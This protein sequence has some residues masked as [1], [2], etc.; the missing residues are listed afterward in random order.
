MDVVDDIKQR[1]IGKVLE[2][3]CMKNYTTYKI[4]G[5]VRLMVYPKNEEKLIELIKVAREY[6]VKYKVVGGGSN[7]I[8]SDAIY[9][10]III[11][12]DNF[13]NL[14]IDDTVVTVGAGYSLMKL[15]ISVSRKGLSGLE[16]ATGIPGTVGGAIYM[17]AGAYKSDMGY[18]VSK[19]KVLT[20][21]L[22]MKYLYNSDMDFHYRT[23]FIQKNTE[24]ICLEA[25][26]VLKHG[27]KNE[28]MAI[29]EDRK[30][31]RLISQP[32]EFPSAGSVF[33]NPDNDFAGRLIEEC[34][35]KGVQVGGAMVSPKH[36]NF[37]VNVS[38]A[39]AL[40]VKKLI[41]MVKEKVKEQF[42]IELKV[43]QEFINWE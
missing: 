5:N 41:E 43:E 15:A 2:D 32:L 23:S 14:D 19:V 30:Q 18:I 42:R 40:D 27:D 28:I 1:K 12:L 17:N 6:K 20:P 33:R 35:F 37:I 16:F 22:E 31:R 24:Y 3:V 9:D 29:I 11:K 10:G 13:N 25:T 26:I 34:G 8:F 21:D 4:G 7:V 39:T 36:A 38:N